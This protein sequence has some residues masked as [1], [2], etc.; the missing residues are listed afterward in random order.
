MPRLV[1]D[2]EREVLLQHTANDPI[3]RDILARLFQELRELREHRDECLNSSELELP[4][5][6]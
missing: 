1:S 4:E 6:G 2:H 3:A 5:G